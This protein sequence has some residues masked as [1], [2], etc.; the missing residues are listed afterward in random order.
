MKLERLTE[1]K[2]KE[3]VLKKEQLMKLNGGGTKTEGGTN[4]FHTSQGQDYVV[5]YTYDVQ[6]DGWPGGLTFHGFY[7]IRPADEVIAPAG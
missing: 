4:L 2:F 7:N 6:R 3:N 5:D 1:E